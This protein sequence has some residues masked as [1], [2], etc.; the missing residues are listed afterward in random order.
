M[1]L[2]AQPDLEV[3]G[4]AADGAQ[5]VERLRRLN[6][7]VVLMD[8][9][10]PGSTASRR[11]GGSLR[12]RPGAPKVLVLTTFD[13]DE[14]VYAAISAGRE[15]VPAEGAPPRRTRR[16]RAHGDRRRRAAGAG[17]TRRLL[18]RFIRRPAPSGAVPP[19]LADLT[20]RELEVL[21]LIADGLLERRDRRPRCS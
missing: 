1:I 2:D 12:R 16:R 11:R 3:V 6:P 15:R 20:A 19:Q 8:V 14:Y 17:I 4:E 10:M 9:R 18:E 5:A 13:L 7:D 21:R